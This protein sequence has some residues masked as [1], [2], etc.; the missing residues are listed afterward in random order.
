MKTRRIFSCLLVISFLIGA[1]LLIYQIPYV[2][3]R[4]SW[5]LTV[6]Q[7]EIRDW[8]APHPETIATPDPARM[9]EAK[10]T[11]SAMAA[12]RPTPT[13]VRSETPLPSVTPVPTRTR[14]PL[15]VR[16][17]VPVEWH[18]WQVR[19]NCG[20]A[21]LSF[22]LRFWGWNGDQNTVGSV[23][24]PS[25]EDKNVMPEELAQ[26]AA[27]RSELEVLLRTGG[28]LDDLRGLIAAGFPVMVEMGLT[29]EEYHLGWMGHYSL[30]AGYDD[31]T[32]EFLAQDS[33]RGQDF[34]WEYD[35]LLQNW[36]AFNFTYLVTFPPDRENEV[37]AVL[38]P[39]ADPSVNLVNTLALARRETQTLG[40]GS[41][42]FAFFNL[43]SSLTALGKYAEAAAAFD[44][45]RALGL[46]W[47]FLWYQIGPYTA[48][49]SSGRYQDV[50]TLAEETLSQQ[51]NLEE[52]W[53]W[54]G[55]ARMALGD[56]KGAVADW[57]E[58]LARHPGYSPAQYQLTN[59][60]ETQ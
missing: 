5:R 58:A 4:A 34:H 35:F 47:R 44:Q 12:V 53:Y 3:D 21:S 27:D 26:F 11:L 39:N 22:M 55:M 19:N 33:Y 18:E 17:R 49:Y 38:G 29:V 54:R 42:T 32:R 20:P 41:L 6:L 40:G 52:S 43:G 45:A 1:A 37:K 8:I 50:I 56:R 10:A 46:P 16:A 51:L 15:P 31:K 14:P 60:G 28:S 36:R 25:P 23:L 24:H 9:E 13:P 48:Y 2:H 30:L 57:R 59:A 7:A